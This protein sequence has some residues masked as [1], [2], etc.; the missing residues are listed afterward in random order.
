MFYDM[1]RG[2]RKVEMDMAGMGTEKPNVNAQN[3]AGSGTK[4]TLANPGRCQQLASSYLGRGMSRK[5]FA[6]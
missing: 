2:I 5:Q 6:Y 3:V 1:G 4:A